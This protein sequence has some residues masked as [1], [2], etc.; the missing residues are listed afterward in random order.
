LKFDFRHTA[1]I[2][3]DNLER[4]FY[5]YWMGKRTAIASTADRVFYA[6][7]FS[8]VGIDRIVSEAGVALGTLY[9]HFGSKSGL[10]V[11]ALEH[12]HMAYLA[13]L[14]NYT[15]G[16]TGDDRVLCLFDSLLEWAERNG[17]N[18]CFFL[19]AAADHPNDM[20]IKE[21]AFGHKQLVLELIEVRLRESGR[22]GAISR[23]LAAP[24]YILLEGAVA[25]CPILGDRAAILIARDAASELLSK[26]AVRRS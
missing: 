4:S 11:A 18:G 26:E 23:R 1:D 3:F 14:E 21:T 24:I 12:R 19:R 13:E 16:K 17:G 25:A 20:A 9:N 2:P 6:E 15:A 10:V 5:R 8:G 22:S 7:G